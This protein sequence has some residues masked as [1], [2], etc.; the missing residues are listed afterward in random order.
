MT[1]QCLILFVAPSSAPVITA[2][3]AVN[4]RIV[5]LHWNPPPVGDHNGI[6]RKY[7]INVTAV[8]TGNFLQTQTPGTLGIISS[9]I[10]SFTYKFSVAA[11]TVS[12]GPYSSVVTITMPE[13]GECQ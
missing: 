4:S 13:D 2:S 6:I 9:L 8:Q 12:A 3:Y 10:P 7:L 1:H 11:Y 5:A